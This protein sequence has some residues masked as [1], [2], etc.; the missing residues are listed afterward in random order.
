MPSRLHDVQQAVIL[1]CVQNA[2]FFEIDNLIPVVVAIALAWEV[3][4]SPMSI[5]PFVCFHS[6]ACVWV[7]TMA[8]RGLKLKVTGQ[9][10]DAVSLTSKLD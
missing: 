6:F 8:C 4:Q 9:G 7:T 2:L 3:M 5:C 10:Q 1:Q